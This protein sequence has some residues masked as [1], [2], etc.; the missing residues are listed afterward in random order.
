LR[1][2]PAHDA[3][4]EWIG[5]TL[6]VFMGA[7]LRAFRIDWGLPGYAF[8]DTIIHFV[9]PAAAAV[10]DGT[11]EPGTCVHP[12]LLPLLLAQLYRAWSSVT[13]DPILSV[14]VGVTPQVAALVQIGR[15]ITVIFST[16][17]IVA[18]HLVARPLVGPR[19]ALLATAAFAL[20]PLHILESHR[21]SSDIPM[22]FLLLLATWFA[23][24]A[25]G[26]GEH[27][28]ILASFTMAGFSAAT[29]Y[30]GIF[31]TLLPA[32]I[33]LRQLSLS[34]R[35]RSGLLVA[36]GLLTLGAFALG[37]VPCLARP[38]KFVNAFRLMGTFAYVVGMPGVDLAAGW[39][40]HRFV[41]P[42]VVALPYMMGWPVYVAAI[43]GFVL[44]WRTQRAIAGLL[45]IATVP[46]LLFMGGGA[47]AV[48]RYYLQLSPFLAMAAG[49]ALARWSEG[50]NLRTLGGLAILG[51]LGYTAVVSASQ[52]GRLGLGPQR[53]VGDL[54]ARIQAANA[55][56]GGAP[57]VVAYPN[58][59]A[60]LYDAVGRFLRR[61]A[62]K[63]VEL[64]SPY[65]HAG[66]DPVTVPDA[67][68]TR[69]RDL[70]WLRDTGVDIIVLPSWIENTIA[71]A[72]PQ[73]QTGRFFRQLEDGELQ[74][75]FT[76]HFR[77]RYATEP[78]YTWGDPML[79]THWET[80]IAGYKVF[81]R[82]DLA[83]E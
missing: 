14:G 51:V 44:L 21:V 32:W 74:F 30:T 19:A 8:P 5:L 66:K 70:A 71:R 63:I 73:G 52:V 68:V 48:P 78:L 64:P 27:R 29:K 11:F 80:A 41:Y 37:A 47:S 46:Y 53:A 55:A 56:A 9:R 83:L 23:V 26:R 82:E 36:G 33:V 57:L 13:G 28:W 10:V 60:L 18:A 7:A 58:R 15:W 79:D 38:D 75:D 20:N 2:H 42:L 22:I 61:P 54:L 69:A 50:G 43:A 76:G 6:I 12:P 16:L 65:N 45:L 49:A 59:I 31:A 1:Q 24:V 35:Q 17:S 4:V 81:T 62:V 67:E 3:R 77:N 25:R 39:T 34:A 40:Q 72:R